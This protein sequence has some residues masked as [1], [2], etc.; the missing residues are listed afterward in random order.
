ME[1]WMELFLL[2]LAI[3]LVML[4]LAGAAGLVHSWGG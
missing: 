3:V 2:L 1:D 4:A